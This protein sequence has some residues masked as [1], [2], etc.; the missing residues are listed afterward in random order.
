MSGLLARAD[1]FMVGLLTQSEDNIVG[2]MG[3][4]R[5]LYALFY[6][7]V[8]SNYHYAQLAEIP[9]AEWDPVL[10]LSFLDGPLNAAL[11][12]G[13]EYLL[14][15]GLIFVLFGFQTRLATLVVLLAGV[16]LTMHRYSFGKIDHYDT[17]L[18]A[19]IPAL[20]L[21]WDWGKSYSVD[22]LLRKRRGQSN[23]D[24][25]DS[26]WQQSWPVLV[27]TISLAILFS[28]SAILKGLPDG[29][30]ITQSDVILKL[31]M[32]F[33]RGDVWNP[34]VPIVVDNPV[35]YENLRW[36]AFLFELGWVLALINKKWRTLFVASSVFFHLYIFTFLQI[37]F[38]QMLFTY[39]FFIDWQM[40]YDRYWP[41][42]L[43]FG[44]HFE[45]LST[46][47]LIAMPVVLAVVVAGLWNLT[48][49]SITR[50]LF[51][52]VPDAVIWVIAVVT[53]TI[54]LIRSGLNLL[55]DGIKLITNQGQGPTP[56]AQ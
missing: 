20:M 13:L 50:T 23:L 54:L 7:W 16:I 35:L 5:I 29:S 25:H 4:Y 44:D 56:A 31:T 2:R 46:P 51:G 17:Y 55:Q 41:D 27:M 9:V 1:Q 53:A 30:W 32:D 48:D 14:V 6:L 11:L 47:M 12:Q 42:A 26:S 34:L 33:N 39:A 40:L 43:K 45:K 36:G 15:G 18:I 38:V 24:V 28:T 37:S 22:A 3:L 49:P 8:I 10:T 19:Y 21:L 52:F